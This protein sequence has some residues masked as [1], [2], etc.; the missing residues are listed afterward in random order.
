MIDQVLFPFDEVAYFAHIRFDSPNFLDHDNVTEDV[1]G[2]GHLDLID[3]DINEDGELSPGED[4]DFDGHLDVNEDINENLILDGEEGFFDIDLSAGRFPH[5]RHSVTGFV[6]VPRPDPAR[7]FEPPYPVVIYNHGYGLMRIESLILSAYMARHGFATVAIDAAHHGIGGFDPLLIEIAQNLL[8][9]Q[10]LG[11]LADALVADGALDLN[12][13][14]ATDSGSDFLTTDAVHT[15]DMVRQTQV[16]LAQVVRL[17]RSFDGETTISVDIDGSGEEVDVLAGDFDRDGFVDLGGPDVDLY[18]AGNSLGGINTTVMAGL[19]PNI[20]AAA[21]ISGGGYLSSIGLRSTIGGVQDAGILPALGPLVVT[22]HASRY[23]SIL[24]CST[25]EDCPRGRDCLGGV[26]RCEENRDCSGQA[27]FRCFEPPTTLTEGGSICADQGDTICSFGQ[28]SARFVVDDLN[29]AADVE[30]A[31]IDEEDLQPGD[32]LVVRNLASQEQDCFVAWPG[33]RS[34]MSLPTD[35][36][37]P[38]SLTVYAGEVLAAGDRCT[39]RADAEPRRVV[40][41]FEIETTFQQ[42]EWAAGEPLVAPRPGFGLRRATPAL[43]RMLTIVQIL[44]DPADPA[45][46]A[47]RHFLDPVDYGDETRASPLLNISTIGDQSVPISNGIAI[48]RSAG[49]IDFQRL[50]PRLAD[51]EHPEGMT[52]DRYLIERGVT[53]GAQRLSIWRRTRDDLQVA[54]DPDDLDRSVSPPDDDWIG[55]G[56]DAPSDEVPLRIWRPLV[57]GEVCTCIDASGEHE[58]TWPGDTVGVLD[59]VRCPSGVAGQTFAYFK[60]GGSHA[61]IPESNAQFDV[62]AFISNMI[63][64]YFATGGTELRWNL[65]MEDNTCTVEE[66]GFYTP[67]LRPRDEEE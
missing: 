47:R 2:D 60:V 51:A 63:G 31:C 40:D 13:D 33:S 19:E 11:P 43:R 37:A 36:H 4:L 23:F 29:S 22:D 15:R 54:F 32:T 57:E 35:Q 5:G 66:E 21:P 30:F 44:L 41:T 12:G 8:Q 6:T 7:G 14:G 56:F 67:P 55:D 50:D 26:C 53:V 45:N 64:R 3:E 20:I 28:V 1:D 18:A 49:I 59:M 10:N 27:G 25:D 24:R 17:I 48:A 34:R 39:L 52:H 42:E 58:C 61:L 9:N 16:D 46:L 62:H 38:V 65:C